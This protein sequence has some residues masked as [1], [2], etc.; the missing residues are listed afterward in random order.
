MSVIRILVVEDEEFARETLIDYLNIKGFTNI[1]TATRGKEAL[2]KIG[3]EKPDFVFLDIQ[4]A[5]NTDGMEVLRQSRGLSPQTK[6]I[7]MSAYQDEHG[8][9]ADEL[10]AFYFLKKPIRDLDKVIKVMQNGHK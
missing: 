1:S 7:M 10:G 3:Q 6:C 4:L 9:K 5:D 8:P 2:E